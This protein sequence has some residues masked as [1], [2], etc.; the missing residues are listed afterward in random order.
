MTRKRFR[1]VEDVPIED[2]LLDSHNPRIR[3]GADQHDCIERILRDRSNFQNLLKDIAENGLSPE[4]I[5]VSRNSEGKWIVRDGNR[6]VTALKLLNR[7]DLC[8]QDKA[9]ELIAR[10]AKESAPAGIPTTIDCIAC[11]D[12][13]IIAGYLERKHTGENEGVG[14]RGWSALVQAL[15]NLNAGHRDI[16]RRAAQLILWA[17]ERGLAVADDYPITTLTRGLNTEHL[18]LIGFKVE[19]DELV[20]TLPDHQSY[21]LAARVINA[22]GTGEVN[23]KRTDEP[24]SIFT[25]EAQLAFFTAV[26][27]EIGP[28]LEPAGDPKP[29]ASPQPDQPTQGG[30]TGGDRPKPDEQAD[31]DPEDTPGGTRPG[32]RAS[33]SPV[34]SPWERPYLFGMRKSASPGC[35]IP[36][37]Q[38]KAQQIVSELRRVDVTQ[39]PLAVTMLLRALL[40]TS[41]NY[42]RARHNL[43]DHGNLHQNIARSA[44]HMKAANLLTE[45]QHAVAMRHTRSE[46]SL[47]HVKTIQA[48][49]H[50]ETFFPTQQNINV[51]W[52]ELCH[53]IRACW[54]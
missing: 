8:A 28:P 25:P 37:T 41:D 21:A 33:P 40:E 45:N 32:G 12:E 42:Y 3:H 49:I 38:K 4:H 44:D 24:G 5:L 30:E 43:K 50:K 9:F 1:S 23:M 10:R 6:R 34:S 19:A 47:V 39:T 53:F 52:D 35:T 16:H 14:Q 36:D 48:I 29:E 17:E 15:F 26:R 27:N 20:P 54:R 31:T 13:N 11:D 2:L 51:T 18:K 7:P 46:A 22:V